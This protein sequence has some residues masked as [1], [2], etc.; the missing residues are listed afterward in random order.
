M[1]PGSTIGWSLVALQSGDGWII[2]HESKLLALG[3]MHSSLLLDVVIWPVKL[4]LLRPE[5][6]TMALCFAHSRLQG[7]KWLEFGALRPSKDH[8]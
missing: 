2:F 1:M 8:H 7:N 4:R 5:I 3:L 6:I